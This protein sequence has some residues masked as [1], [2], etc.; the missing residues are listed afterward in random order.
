M[1]LTALSQVLAALQADSALQTLLGGSGRVRFGNLT[2]SQSIPGVYLTGGNTDKSTPNPGYLVSRH[3]TNNDTIRADAW[4]T[5][6]EAVQALIDRV[7]VVILPGLAGFLGTERSSGMA[8][9]P[10]PD[11]P[12]LWHA[13][14]TYTFTYRVLDS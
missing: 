11:Q 2:A 12:E 6:P 5:T 7:D 13:A 8:A 9:T 4:A 14:A 1:T 10:D 3:R